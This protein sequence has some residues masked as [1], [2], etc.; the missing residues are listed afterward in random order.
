MVYPLDRV[1]PSLN[2]PAQV[3]KWVTATYRDGLASHPGA[4]SSQLLHAKESEL[5]R[6]TGRVGH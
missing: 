1:A 3:Y 6:G 5:S 2:N 4:S